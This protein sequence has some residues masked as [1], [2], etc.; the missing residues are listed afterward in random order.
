MATLFSL[1]PDADAVLGMTPEELGPVLLRLALPRVQGAGFIPH[2]VAQ[3]GYTP[4]YD[5]A[6][7]STHDVVEDGDYPAHK[8]QT[9]QELVNR[10]WDMLEREGFIEPSLSMNGQYGWRQFS[11]DGLK[12]ARGEVKLSSDKRSTGGAPLNEPPDTTVR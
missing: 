3:R 10:T 7:N 11:E 9:V 6:P 5:G 4:S 1:F 2:T 8:K 12:V